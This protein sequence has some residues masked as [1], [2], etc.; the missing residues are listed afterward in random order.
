MR[1]V[2]TFG[3]FN[4]DAVA[5]SSKIA[6]IQRKQR[7]IMEFGYY[8]EIG[9]FHAPNLSL[10]AMHFSKAG[11]EE[12]AF[13]QEPTPTIW[14]RRADGILLGCAYMRA[15]DKFYAGWHK[16]ALGNDREVMSIST[17]PT[18]NGRSESLYVVTVDPADGIYWVEMLTGMFDDDK[19]DWACWFTDSAPVPGSA[20]LIGTNVRYYGLWHLV[21]KT[22]Q[23]FVAGLDLGDYVVTS[24]GYIDVP[25][26]A[27][28]G[29]F[30]EAYLAGYVLNGIDFGEFAVPQKFTSAVVGPVGISNSIRA[31][32]GADGHVT[33]VSGTTCYPDDDNGFLY[34]FKAGTTTTSGLRKF[35]SAGTSAEILNA[36]KADLG[37]IGASRGIQD[38]TGA[39]VMDAS[40]H[41]YITTFFSNTSEIGKFSPDLSPVDGFVGVASGG[42]PPGLGPFAVNSMAA[43]K[44]R[45]GNTYLASSTTINTFQITL[46]SGDPPF[47]LIGGSQSLSGAIASSRA[48]ICG[49]N[50]KH[51][52]AIFYVMDKPV[53]G[54]P[55]TTAWRL[56]KITLGPLANI[57]PPLAP[58]PVVAFSFIKAIAPSD[59][60]ATWTNFS[61]GCGMAYDQTD[62]NVLCQFFTT[63]AV[64]VTKYLAKISTFDGS[65]LWKTAINNPD[66]HG[67]VNFNKHRIVNSRY[68]Y[69]DGST[70]YVFNTTD[71][72]V[73]TQNYAGVTLSGG[74][75][76]DDK[77]DGTLTFLGGYNHL[78]GTAT[79]LGSYM[80]ANL[81]ATSQWLRIYAGFQHG[82]TFPTINIYQAPAL[83]GLGYTSQAQLLRPDY[84][85]DAGAQAGPA[86]G[87]L[88]RPHQYAMA[89]Y[90]TRQVDIGTEFGK[91]RP[92]NFKFEGGTDIPMPTLN[93]GT[94]A[95]GLE[96]RDDFE[97]K[98]AWQQDRPFPGVFLAVA[99]YLE[100]KD[101]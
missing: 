68:L 27:A 52:H 14:A 47:S 7:K 36:N 50:P 83:F 38:V 29:L 24:G 5:T 18:Y 78:A 41:M 40:K 16:H 42:T 23:A 15:P 4:A 20:L 91:L 49:G 1:R 44:D 51:D 55:A 100:C 73:T 89:T 88:R 6:F 62:G 34:E 32:V 69:L 39:S 98:I 33:G 70:L 101:K 66:A 53:Y 77:Y 74:Q 75:I 26:D 64:A 2:S 90:R 22:V 71:G 81:D 65:I 35:L 37:L 94:W 13:Q 25:L 84:G 80:I 43:T 21:G 61:G 85:Q 12:I 10:P 57:F 28:G 19:D 45:L 58:S 92:I 60:D 30:T 63:D 96:G 76:S 9:G 99:G 79:P 82:V 72:S 11:I 48:V 87:K 93:T 59:V 56:H 97:G 54:A 17:G 31:Y 46:M 95:G 86:F 3:S 8:Q 67:D